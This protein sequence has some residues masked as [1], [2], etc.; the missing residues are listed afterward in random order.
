MTAV[1]ASGLPAP[2]NWAITSCV[3]NMATA[4]RGRTLTGATNFPGAASTSRG[5]RASSREDVGRVGWL[6]HLPSSVPPPPD[7]VPPVPDDVAA[8]GEG[9]PSAGERIRR[10]QDTD[11]EE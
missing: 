7:E 10:D 8:R 6:S 4:T 9:D 3:K 2:T 5:R 11:P 1:T